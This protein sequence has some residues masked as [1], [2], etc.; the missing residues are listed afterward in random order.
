MSVPATGSAIPETLSL[1]AR[2]VEAMGTEMLRR[3]GSGQN[4]ATAVTSHL[5]TAHLMGLT[6]HGIIRFVQYAR[7]IRS[8]RID[9]A[10]TP[11]IDLD[12][13]SS[14]IVDGW[15]GFGQLT[16]L[17]A[18]EV[19]VAKA[20]AGGISIVTTRR[21][22]HVGRLGAYVEDAARQG[23][24]AIAV[25]AV[26]RLGHFVVPWGG[27]EGRM[28]T[29]PIAYGFPTLG[30]PI[31]ADFATSVI[32]EGR[33]RTARSSGT[34][35][36]EGAVLDANGL[37]TRDPAAF[38]GPPP[39]TILPFGGISGHKGFGLAL[40]VELLGATLAGVEPAS[41]DRSIN[42]YTVVAINASAFA[43]INEVRARATD[44]ATYVRSSRPSDPA[45]PV[46]V[47]GEPEFSSLRAAG[48][49]A[50]V[51]IDASTWSD[52]VGV[53]D[54]VGLDAPRPA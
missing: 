7:D 6:S 8:G 48:D 2:D 22:N 1:R 23:V 3:L 14:A 25:A 21:C 39:G 37:P 45:R 42:G 33:I 19:A 12:R 30:D 40:L 44:L 17:K 46:M 24:C 5:M 38:Y 16:A 27:I 50:V 11:T 32:P 18:T 15:G 51:T 35:L 4:A 43:D 9:P 36:P 26:P 20:R 53:A 29:N 13:P 10:A 28:G 49:D 52:L 41:D 54:S 47:P 31:V 34:Q